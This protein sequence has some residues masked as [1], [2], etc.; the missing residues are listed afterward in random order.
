M[1][2]RH[3]LSGLCLYIS[4]R[5]AMCNTPPLSSVFPAMT[6]EIERSRV[7]CW[8]RIKTD[9]YGMIRSS[10]GGFHRSAGSLRLLHR[11]LLLPDR[12]G[13]ENLPRYARKRPKCAGGFSFN[14]QPADGILLLLI[15]SS[16]TELVL[17]SPGQFCDYWQGQLRQAEDQTTRVGPS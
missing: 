17:A 1:L 10:N 5:T 2:L 3:S 16:R 14:H 15:F 11:G 9:H 12:A 4:R 8:W 6:I 13:K 7:F